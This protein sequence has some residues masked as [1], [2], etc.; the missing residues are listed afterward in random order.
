MALID[1]VSYYS[2]WEKRG[3]R[4]AVWGGGGGGPEYADA[5]IMDING[6]ETCWQDTEGHTE[7]RSRNGFVGDHQMRGALCQQ[8]FCITTLTVSQH[9]RNWI[10]IVDTSRVAGYLCISCSA[11]QY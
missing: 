1:S 2:W 4:C 3:G 6:S 9:G 10:R 5:A 8:H 7:Q 11:M